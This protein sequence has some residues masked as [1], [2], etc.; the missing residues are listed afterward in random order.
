MV[1]SILAAS[2]PQNFNVSANNILQQLTLSWEI[3][4]TTNGKIILH[5]YCYTRV[6]GGNEM[7]G[8]TIDSSTKLV[9]ITNLG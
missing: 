6:S 4:S 2:A 8:D 7:C 3:P 1:L 5:Q 9:N